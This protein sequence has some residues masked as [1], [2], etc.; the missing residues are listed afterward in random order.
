MALD[1]SALSA[2]LDA[3]RTGDGVDVIR[4]AV[5][6]VM[7]ELIETEACGVI[8]AEPYERTP[9]RTTERNGHRDRV[10]STKAGISS[11]ASRSCVGARSFRPSSNPGDVSTRPSTRWS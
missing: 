6:L 10:P 8:G 5:R 9:T 1:E 7:Q 11:C 3:F 2:L 4:D